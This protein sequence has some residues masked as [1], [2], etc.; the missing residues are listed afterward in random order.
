MDQI[1]VRT[2]DKPASASVPT[3]KKKAKKTGRIVI[4]ALIVTVLAL[5]GTAAYF[6]S[7]YQK[8]KNNPE[9]VAKEETASL[10]KSIGKLMTL[11]TGETPNVATIIDKEKLKDQPFFNNAENGDKVLIY[12][13]AQKAIIYRP[14]TNKIINV[15]PI[16][17]N[18]VAVAVVNAGGNVADT[19]K[20][21][22]D[23]FT[24]AV[25]VVATGDAKNKNAISKTTVVDVSGQNSKAAQDIATALGGTVGSMP[26]GESTPQGAS[27][28]V[29]VK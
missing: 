26:A 22:N 28:V 8:V 2:P 25:N 20:K 29:F 7:K 27:I 14:S 13:K 16:S 15:G 11:P 5:G 10:E 17:L 21:L 3:K 1:T 4:V 23:T 12:T 19:T 24:T 9:T 6:Y 18:Q